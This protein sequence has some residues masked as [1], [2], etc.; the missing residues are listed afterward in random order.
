MRHR[1]I[2]GLSGA[3]LTAPEK[4]FLANVRPAGLIL[5]A[6]NCND[7]D[8]I[9]QLID[10]AKTAIAADDILVLIDQEGGRVM[11]MR[12]PIAR[13]LPPAARYFDA[14]RRDPDR[15]K[16][17]AFQVARLLSED[18]RALGIN[19]NCAPVLDLP[20]PG[21]HD[22][23]GDRAY[24]TD[25]HQVITLAAEVAKGFLAGAVL[26]VI[27]HIPGH[28][29][30]TK[31]SHLELPIV[32]AS[33]SELAAN[34]FKPFQALAHLPA[35]MTAHV[36]YSA[37]DP[38]APASTSQKVTNEIIRGHIGFDG[39]L[40]SDDVSM[41]A[42]TGTFAKRA[43]S[44]IQAGSDIVLHCNGKMHEMKTVA[45]N[46]PQLSG[47]SKRRFDTAVK[48]TESGNIKPF[49]RNLAEELLTAI[50]SGDTQAPESV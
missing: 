12:P 46:V 10:D 43:Q 11:R 6:R 32:T 7:H 13:P 15:A 44:V 33:Q 36:V 4:D 28:G 26:P 31:D 14:Y 42:L 20:V 23:V 8:Q 34:D 16:A 22:I 50:R 37:I 5:F 19:C 35:A 49:D 41:K 24:G 47:K 21:A 25:P 2:T 38:D 1:L 39:L 45:A 9:R 48:A 3:A 17:A 30:A 18:L 29:R 27:K 40:M